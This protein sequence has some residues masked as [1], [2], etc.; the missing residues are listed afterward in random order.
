MR[1][2]ISQCGQQ[3]LAKESLQPHVCM[4][5]PVGPAKVVSEV[6]GK[7]GREAHTQIE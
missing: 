3:E 7:R 4:F 2:H 5:A 6:R 1:T